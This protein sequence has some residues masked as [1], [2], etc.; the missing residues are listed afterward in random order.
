[1]NWGKRWPYDG[2]GSGS[3]IKDHGEK[4]N[5]RVMGRDGGG[6][7]GGRSE[8]SR[9]VI[10]GNRQQL[11]CLESESKRKVSETKV[12]YGNVERLKGLPGNPVMTKSQET[13]DLETTGLNTARERKEENNGPLPSESDVRGLL[14]LGHVGDPK[15]HEGSLDR[16]ISSNIQV[17]GGRDQSNVLM[18]LNE[19]G[20]LPL[21]PVFK[22]RD[23]NN[24]SSSITDPAKV[25]DKAS[26]QI[27]LGEHSLQPVSAE[28][29]L[30]STWKR[31]ARNK[32]ISGDTKKVGASLGEKKK[33][34][35][36][37]KSS[38][39]QKK[40]RNQLVHNLSNFHNMG[41]LDT[42]EVFHWAIAYLEEWKSGQNPL[43]EGLHNFSAEVPKWRPPDAGVWKINTD[44]ASCYKERLIG[45]GLISLDS[46]GKVSLAAAQNLVAMVSP[47]VAEALAVRNGI[48]LAC[49]AGFVPFLLETDS[50]Q[51]VN[52][53]QKG[54]HSDAEVGLIIAE[55]DGALQSL[56]NCC[57]GHVPRKGNAAAHTLARKALS[58]ESEY[59]WIDICPPCVERIVQ[60]DSPL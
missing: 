42:A 4:G 2:R 56:S 50:L 9:M 31:R 23:P 25:L 37:G 39:T 46:G 52:M 5:W 57:I 53:V 54:L 59:R 33:A 3:F 18:G 1:M 13:I 58:V 38:D 41:N 19:L 10:T 44:A 24:Q 26:Q 20:M 45:L 51:V 28:P 55:I 48:H 43:H 21:G 35:D 15:G 60:I 14:S 29:N 22:F 30:L 32:G 12:D 27:V 49:E 40:Q 16:W 47:L 17:S 11:H 36:E 7:D 8:N 34:V 6:G